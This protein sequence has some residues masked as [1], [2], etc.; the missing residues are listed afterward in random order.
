MTAFSLPD[1]GKRKVKPKPAWTDTY[2]GPKGRIG[3]TGIDP[4]SPP[5]LSRGS[6][7]LAE[8]FMGERSSDKNAVGMNPRAQLMLAVAASIDSWSLAEL[9]AVPD[10]TIVLREREES[11]AHLYELDIENPLHRFVIGVDP[12]ANFMIRHVECLKPEEMKYSASVSKFRA[13]G[14][15]V[16][17]PELVTT[18]VGPLILTTSF[19][20]YVVNEPLDS[21]RFTITFPEWL[22]VADYKTGK[23]FVWGSD[24]PKFTFDSHDDFWAWKRPYF[25]EEALAR[26][27][28][29]NPVVASRA[30]RAPTALIA[31][32]IMM[33]VLF[34]LVLLRR[35]LAHGR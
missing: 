21:E 16:Y 22:L 7:V 28:A 8:G 25:D 11:G 32:G 10:T 35:R 17:L 33:A 30:S 3:T 9:A 5:T 34:T 14:D 20:S 15:G 13:F 24:G 31:T 23:Y 6:P 1:E 27:Q 29:Q 12:E 18:T 4:A 26:V 2:N 19:S